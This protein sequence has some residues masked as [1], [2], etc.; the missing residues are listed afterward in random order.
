LA[1]ELACWGVQDANVLALLDPPPSAGLAQAREVLGRLGAIGSDHRVTTHGRAM[2][3][4]GVHPRL[5]HMLLRGQELGHGAL[6]ADLAALLAERDVLARS[7]PRD[8]DLRTRLQWLERANE[9][10]GLP[11]H[12]DA[13][14]LRSARQLSRQFRRLLRVDERAGAASFREIHE[15]AGLLVA[16]AYPDR[17]AQRRSPDSDGTQVGGRPA[18]Y[19]LAQGRGALLPPGE[20]LGKEPW[21]AVAQLD[22]GRTANDTEPEITLAAPLEE[23]AFS[24]VLASGVSEGLRVIWDAREE[25]VVARQERTFGALVLHGREARQSDPERVRQA[26]LAG[27]RSIGPTAL[28][29][30]KTAEA[31]RE[32]IAF[33]GNVLATGPV[34]LRSGALDAATW[35]A[36]DL[37]YLWENLPDW[38][39]PWLDGLSRRSHL[40]RVDL[41]AALQA[42]LDGPQQRALDELAPTHF[43]VPS[44]SRIPID[45]AEP[46]APALLVRLQEVFGLSTTPRLGGGRVPLVLHLLS[47]GHRPVQVTRDLESFWSRGYAEVKKEL[48]GRYPKHYWPDDPRTAQATHRAKP[49]GT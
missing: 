33:I 46:S 30:T 10:G 12:V 19:L 22:G 16:M 20:P 34:H 41:P 1:L 14:A 35:P 45:Y 18:R 21:L 25:A 3:A 40:S 7:G 5:A 43:T 13:N 39:A 6:A 24:T 26:L 31:L 48:K 28:P 29:W 15:T 27:I 36:V 49:R 38:L 23:A 17:V 32:R 37:I 44:G 42:M 8:A 9:G 11:G 4:L 2:A 47:P